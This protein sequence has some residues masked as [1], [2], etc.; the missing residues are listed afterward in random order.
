MLVLVMW[1]GW[2]VIRYACWEPGIGVG[3]SGMES[4]GMESMSIEAVMSGM[5]WAVP[6]S[7]F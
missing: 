1:C 3:R 5:G 4:V 7:G 6:G 2:I